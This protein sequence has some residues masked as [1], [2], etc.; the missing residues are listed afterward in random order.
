M[1]RHSMLRPKAGGANMMGTLRGTFSIFGP[2]AAQELELNRG[3]CLQT[4][5][6]WRVLPTY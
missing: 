4:Y 2:L 6:Q 1:D 5:S 3:S